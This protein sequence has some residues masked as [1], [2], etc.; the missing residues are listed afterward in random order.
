MLVSFADLKSSSRSNSSKRSNRHNP[1][2]DYNELL[3]HRF[4]EN[5]SHR[6]G[7]EAASTGGAW[8][9]LCLSSNYFEFFDLI[10]PVDRSHASD[11]AAADYNL[12]YRELIEY[13]ALKIKIAE[14][15]GR[16]HE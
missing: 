10:S 11:Y 2:P 16:R 7:F 15:R 3:Q 12:T 13:P 1:L 8:I 6:G 9:T 14:H 4:S 5:E